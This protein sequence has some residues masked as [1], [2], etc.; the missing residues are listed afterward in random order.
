MNERPIKIMLSNRHAHITRETADI[1]FGDGGLTIGGKPAT[2]DSVGKADGSISI[3]G[4]KGTIDGV[5]ILLRYRKNNQVEL[6]QSDCFRLGVAAPLRMSGHLQDVP[7]LTLTGPCGSVQSPCA[8]VAARHIHILP[9]D[10][11][12]YGIKEGQIVKVRCGTSRSLI[13]ENVEVELNTRV[14]EVG[15]VMHIDFEEG[16][17]AGV[18]NG[19]FGEILL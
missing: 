17:A 15:S 10:A 7:V 4:P 5:R 8:I 14:P 16:N 11:E 2:K 19:D 9:E 18:K 13:F 6:L 12:K 1:L 3:S